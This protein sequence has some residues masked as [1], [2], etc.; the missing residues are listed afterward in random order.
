MRIASFKIKDFRSIETAEV[1][2][3]DLT[4]LVGAN[5]E[6]KS[7]I[8]RAAIAATSQMLGYEHGARAYASRRRNSGALVDFI[9]NRD[10]PRENPDAKPTVE[11][12]LQLSDPE[13]DAFH[14][15]LGHKI[16]GEL[17]FK[18]D[19]Q[20]P[21][22][23][24]VRVVKQRSGGSLTEKSS[25]IADF[26]RQRLRLEY[27]PAVRTAEQAVDVVR[28]LVADQL[29]TLRHDS[30]YLE[31]LELVQ[32]IEQPLLQ[33]IEQDLATALVEFLPDLKDVKIL[34]GGVR[35]AGPMDSYIDVEV[36]D[37]VA[38][39]LAAKGDGVQSL[40]AIALARRAVQRLDDD[41]HHLIL[42][43]EEPETH[44]HPAA[45]RRLR[46]VLREISQE[47]QVIVTTHSPLLIDTE[48]PSTNVIVKNQ[49][50]RPAREVADIRECLGVAVAD[51]LTSA[52]LVL[53][54]EGA[55]D[56][57]T[58]NALLSSSSQQIREM[59]SSG[60]LILEGLG[61]ASKLEARA[62]AMRSAA[63]SVFAVLDSDDEGR[64][65]V[66]SAVDSGRIAP[67]DYLLLSRR[68]LKNSELEDLIKVSAYKSA[69]ESY[70]GIVLESALT[71]QRHLKWSDRLKRGLRDRHK[72][73]SENEINAAK[74]L[75][76]DAVAAMGLMALNADG[77]AVFGHLVSEIERRLF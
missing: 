20:K 45:V 53:L 72:M 56:T 41:D 47:Q 75:V 4:C 74:A 43:I 14:T 8:L 7:N 52:R 60:E 2:L 65:A 55:T 24:G 18:I 33:E 58:F 37:G 6:G 42:A 21:G 19:L 38:T 26:V 44:L 16:N 23:S 11:I 10:L 48:R 62:S 50:A 29:R 32:A 54:L 3:T 22:P 57:A 30:R 25:E 12:S 66:A 61:G 31:A 64:T 51:N 67:G 17:R 76:S 35:M 34:R 77:R 1:P 73:G 46:A 9:P 13:C 27:I 63:C 69:L 39:D 70:F 40:A 49:S 59:C 5:N 68:G 71:E 15:E 36:N 28:R